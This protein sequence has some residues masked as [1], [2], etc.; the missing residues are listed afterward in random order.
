[1]IDYLYDKK[2]FSSIRYF[3]TVKEEH[4]F[5]VKN[6]EEY[7]VLRKKYENVKAEHLNL[8]DLPRFSFKPESPADTAKRILPGVGLL[9][10]TGVLFFIC[11]F[12]A[13]LKYDVR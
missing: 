12:V 6:I 3:A 2:A 11:T 7:D 8:D 9:F 10:F 5:D 4:L 1:L 13:F